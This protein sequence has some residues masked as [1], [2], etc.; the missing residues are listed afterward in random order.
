[1]RVSEVLAAVIFD[2]DGVVVDSERHWATTETS[3]LERNVP[4][5]A[6]LTDRGWIIGLSPDDFHNALARDHGLK[7]SREEFRVGYI[8]MAE[9]IYAEQVQLIPGCQELLDDLG[10]RAVRTALASSS[11]MDWIDRVLNRFSLRER[12]AVV[13]SADAEGLP[14]KPSPAIYLLAAER[15]G[16]KPRDCVAIEDSANGVRSAKAAGMGCV[17][18]RNGFNPEQD[19]SAADLMVAGFRELDG[20]RLASLLSPSAQQS[21]LDRRHAA[22]GPR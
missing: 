17:G 11:P 3:F 4:G 18:L 13:V 19:L 10:R 14:G 8:Q 7:L 2:M 12:F 16:A 5:W 1:M 9:R 15:L 6:D 22:P 20:A 21:A